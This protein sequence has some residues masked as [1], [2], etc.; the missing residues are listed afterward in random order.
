MTLPELLALDPGD[1]DP[2]S[3]H[4]AQPIVIAEQRGGAFSPLLS[5]PVTAGDPYLARTPRAKSE[6]PRL[7]IVK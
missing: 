3:H 2:V 1:I 7:R 4:V 6:R 5:L